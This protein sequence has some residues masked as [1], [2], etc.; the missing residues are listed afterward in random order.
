[1][2]L[3]PDHCYRAL[4]AHDPRF[5]GRF[6]VGVSSTRI[7]CRPICRVRTPKRA[8]CRFF[9]N[10]A[11]AEH[12][13]Y[14]P[15]LRC[16]PELAPGRA[17]VDA[18]DRLAQATALALED[19]LLEDERVEDIA[20]RL[21]VTSRHLRRVFE[22][23]FGVSPSQYRQTQR[24]L[25]AKRL[26]A[27]TAL[28]ITEIAYASG[29]RSLRRFNAAL[30]ERYGL[31]PTDI[32][33]QHAS[34]RRMDTLVVE[35]AYRR[36]FDWSHLMAFLGR[37][38]IRG[39][40]SVQEDA[41]RRTVALPCE[42]GVATGWIAVTSVPARSTLRVAASPELARVLPAVTSRVR[43]LF[44]VAAQP[45]EIAARLGALAAARPGVRVPG[46]FDGF[47]VAVRAILG[48][49]VSVPAATTLAGRLATAFGMPAVT[50]DPM[51]THTFPDAAR[52]AA[53][54]WQE[55]AALGIVGARAKALVTLARTVASKSIALEPS[56][57][58]P[59]MLERLESLPGIGR[60]TAQYIAMRALGWP[61]AFPESDLGIL[62]AL[63]AA[64]PRVA[65][66]RAE[67]WRP[68]RAYAVMHLWHALEENSAQKE[69][70]RSSARPVDR[71]GRARRTPSDSSSAQ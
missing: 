17:S 60:W 62:R 29:F 11:A 27:D 32:R 70:R 52:L 7:Y 58:V 66:E 42:G 49:Q 19:R 3:D 23:A 35:L 33:R 46:A 4:S 71:S 6:F 25:L 13:G 69:D 37:R 55:I 47:E 38:S 14:R 56:A 12:A 65:R 44:D 15:C 21:G 18:A 48:Q 61:D 16:R 45:G 10:A 31:T 57:D 36:P 51:L 9:A 28:P 63:G 34:D 24:L 26:L 20:D 64:G 68:W 50:P 54:D 2:V 22:G 1:M 5:D 67:A 40:E 41:Y 59:L 53:V 30:A 43:R 8:N 39:V